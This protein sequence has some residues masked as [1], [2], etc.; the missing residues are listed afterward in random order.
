MLYGMSY[1][2]TLA[3]EQSQLEL[4]R[5]EIWTHETLNDEVAILTYL[6]THVDEQRNGLFSVAL[7]CQTVVCA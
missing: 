7:Y 6:A 3:A 5:V 2:I 1:A 4:Y